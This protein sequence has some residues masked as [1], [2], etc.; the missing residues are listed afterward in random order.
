MPRPAARPPARPQSANAL[1]SALPDDWN[2]RGALPQLQSL[3]L[4]ANRLSSAPTAWGEGGCAA[5]RDL[6]L[7]GNTFAELPIEWTFLSL[8]TLGLAQNEITGR[9]LGGAA[10]TAQ[11]SRR[12]TARRGACMLASGRWAGQRLLGLSPPL[13][14]PPCLGWAQLWCACVC[15]GAGSIPASW[16]F[17]AT[18]RVV[19]LPQASGVEMCGPVSG[20]EGQR[21]GRHVSFLTAALPSKDCCAR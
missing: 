21:L 7:D 2:T 16:N 11:R 19:V 3:N 18:A 13:L 17:S 9:W 8:Q 20:W 10:G 6:L 15:L 1:T 12:S 14:L 4:R 5:L